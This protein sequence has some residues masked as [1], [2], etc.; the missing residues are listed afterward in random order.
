MDA[1]SEKKLGGL[2]RYEP[3]VVDDI[4]DEFPSWL[5]ADD[6]HANE[7]LDALVAG[8]SLEPT[9]GGRDRL[10]AH[11]RPEGRF[12]RFASTVGTLLDLPVEDAR[13]LLDRLH[14]PAVWVSGPVDGPWLTWWVEGGARTERAIRGFLR[15][16]PGTDFPRHAHLGD[17]S[18]FVLQGSFVDSE[19]VLVE[20][21]TL[22]RMPAGSDHDFRVTEGGPDL[23][24]LTV[25]QEGIHMVGGPV[26]RFDGSVSES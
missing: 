15:I 5:A 1:V 3:V 23:L 8:L 6:P 12:E 17:E 19:G 4:W 26:I 25:A 9:A 14:D 13:A 21:G 11:L 2:A 7:A 18:V 24:I 22:A 20:A 16:K 10:L